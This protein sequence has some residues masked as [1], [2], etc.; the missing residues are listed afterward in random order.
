[1]AACGECPFKSEADYSMA[2]RKDSNVRSGGEVS[3]LSDDGTRVS[4]ADYD[5]AL[6]ARLADYFT[7]DAIQWPR[8]LWD[9]GSLL[10][11]E[12]ILEAGA[13]EAL[14]VLSPA[15]VDWQRRELRKVIGPDLGLGDRELRRELGRVLDVRLPDPSP[16]RRRLGQLIEHARV[17][18]LERWQ[19]SLR[20]ETRPKT[21]RLSRTVAAHLLD[22]GYSRTFLSGWVADRRREGTPADELIAS[23]A[24]LARREP[25]EFEVLVALAKI[26]QRDTLTVGL[27]S[28]RPKN[29]VSNWLNRHGFDT[30][31]VRVGGGFVFRFSAR[32]AH[33][34]A[35]RARA[36]V[37]RLIARSTFLRRD[38][39]GVEPLTHVWVAGHQRPIPLA[40]PARGADVLSLAHEGHM[41]R[42]AGAPS[43]VDDALEL[44]APINRGG[45]GPALAGGWAA[46]ESLLTHPDDPRDDE[47][48]GK[49]VAADRMATIITCS[50]PRA[51]LTSLAH[52][53]KASGP[54]DALQAL[55]A[56]CTT[57][58]ERARV[59]ASVLPTAL[60]LDFVGG[61]NPG[62]DHAAAA[63]MRGLIAA[64]RATLEDVQSALTITLRRLYRSRNI[65]LHGG[66]TQ[67]VALEASLRTAA[68]LV[69]AGLDRIVH[70]SLTEGLAP[71]DLAARAEVSLQLVDGETS[72]SIVEL[73]E[74]PGLQ[75]AQQ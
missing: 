30:A 23:A 73:L 72:H 35:A 49:A 17:G 48:F 33:G 16:A 32:D 31:G 46:V 21:E 43:R 3:V 22:L 38:R 69:G 52:H 60:S 10:G 51:E 39:D 5:R 71:L 19:T 55:L 59:I 14:G 58:M 41:Y 44:A 27:D 24:E 9:V 28:W 8:R 29:E 68:P 53:Y 50:W 36:I 61:R 45:L 47:R 18:Y 62:G 57:N 2:G 75:L 70:A 11:L 66:S 7:E 67:G 4:A 26:P 74:R 12:E 6:L 1:M 54:D 63:R 13:W 56:N 25:R 42:V 15:A 64:P 65:V 40:T 34:A 20:G 37:E